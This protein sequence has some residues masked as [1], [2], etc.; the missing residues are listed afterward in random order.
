MSRDKAKVEKALQSF[1]DMNDE[2]VSLN[3][4]V[5]CS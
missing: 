4:L 5:I 2:V 3:F 1:A